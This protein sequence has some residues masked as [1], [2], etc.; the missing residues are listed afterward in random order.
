MNS[1]QSPKRFFHPKNEQGVAILMVMTSIALLAFLLADFSFETKVNKLRIYNQHDLTQ[2]RL[3][4]E[5]GLSFALAKLK[6]Y[7]E[8]FNI[9]EKNETAKKAVGPRTLETIITQP[10]M[11]PLDES[12]L[13]KASLLQRSAAQDFQ[14]SVA[15][16]GKLVITITPVNGL[17]NPNAMRVP[18]AGNKEEEESE[19]SFDDSSGDKE[20]DKKKLPPHEYIEKQIFDSL[21]RALT[22]KREKDEAF[23]A[24]YGNIDPSLLV[25]ELKFYVNDADR[26]QGPEISDIAGRYQEDN[27]IPKHAPMT[28]ISEMYLLKGW[29]D[30]IIDLIKDNLTVHEVTILPVNELTKAQLKALFPNLTDEQIADYFKFKNGNE[31]EGEPPQEFQSAGDFK[32]AMVKKLNLVDEKSY[33][34]RIKEYENAGIRLGVAGKLFKV[35]SKGEYGRSVYTITA[36]VDLPVLPSPKSK[37]KGEKKPNEDGVTTP[38]E[39][40]DDESKTGKAEEATKKPPMQ[41]MEPRVVEIVLE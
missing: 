7:K 5:S 34:D 18:P 39:S 20:D 23:D 40:E 26:L 6:L 8:G 22:D 19:K 4:A 36:F 17:L 29:D 13:K 1:R 15:L 14:K 41:L 28:S 27:T 35:V 24:R 2:A 37:K 21:T 3:N 10:F 31:A 32:D 25:K 30:P 12:L 11:F 38:D 9:L 33:D 16:L